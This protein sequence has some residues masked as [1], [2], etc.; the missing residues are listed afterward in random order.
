M[1]PL[2]K[3]LVGSVVGG[4]GEVLLPEGS[5]PV[6][7][8]EN[9]DA[10]AAALREVLA[11]PDAARARAA[12]LRQRLVEERSAAAYAQHVKDVLLGTAMGTP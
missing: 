8:Y 6:V 5:W 1:K 12:A 2:S 3:V 4:T 9:P 11:D 7:D 10:Y